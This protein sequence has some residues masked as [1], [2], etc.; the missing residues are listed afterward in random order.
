MRGPDA[1]I[2]LEL[3]LEEAVFGVTREVELRMPVECVR[4]SGS[5]CEPGT[6]PSTCR[7]CGGAGEVRTVR[8]T[9]LGQMMT[10][11]PCSACRATG[12][13]ILSPCRHCRGDG[14]V[15]LPATVEVQVPAGIDA[16]PRLRLAGR[17]PAATRGGEPGGL[18]RSIA[19][20]AHPRLERDGD[21][22][23]HRL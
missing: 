23:L 18:Y 9:I 20:R 1:E 7:T 5:G 6:H 12:R 22:L 8:R 16:R 10:A 15:T 2:S 11:T 19:V 13:E 17:G 4:C 21:A 3:D 14:R